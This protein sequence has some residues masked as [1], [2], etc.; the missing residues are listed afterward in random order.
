MLQSFD[1][2]NWLH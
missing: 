1:D 2:L